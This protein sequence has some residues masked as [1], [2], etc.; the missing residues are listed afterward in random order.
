MN[1]LYKQLIRSSVSGTLTLFLL[2]FFPQALFATGKDGHTSSRSLS[3]PVH[4]RCIWQ[5]TSACEGSAGIRGVSKES[6]DKA[7]SFYLVEPVPGHA[8]LRIRT[9]LTLPPFLVMATRCV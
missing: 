9:G 2:L 5:S 6:H 1:P 8:R 7:Y 4:I 3:A